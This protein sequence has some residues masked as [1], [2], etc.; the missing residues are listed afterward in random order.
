MNTFPQNMPI[1]ERL[2]IMRAEG[3]LIDYL[4]SNPRAR[5]LLTPEELS[6]FEQRYGAQSKGVEKAE[7]VPEKNSG[8]R[9]G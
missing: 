9:K 3:K 8:K 7:P 4:L 1:E 6:L 5:E 2:Q